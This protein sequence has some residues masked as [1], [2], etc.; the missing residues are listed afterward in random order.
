MADGRLSDLDRHRTVT[1]AMDELY[2]TYPLMI[3]RGGRGPSVVATPSR[4]LTEV[5]PSLYEPVV[6]ETELDT[7]WPRPAPE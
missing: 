7:T 3:S 2:L 5:D 1:R 4:F 6:L